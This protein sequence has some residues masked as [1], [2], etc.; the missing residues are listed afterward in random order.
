MSVIEDSIDVEVPIRTAYN[1]WTQ[2]EEFSKFMEGVERVEQRTDTL[3]HWVTKIGGIKREFDAE[4]TDQVPDQKVAWHTLEGSEQR[5]EVTF[6]PLDATHTRVLLHMEF[7]PEGI[8]EK[9]G[10]ALGIV[11]R[12]VHGDLERFK[13][14][15]EHRGA[16]TG[17]WRGEVRGGQEKPRGTP[18]EYDPYRGGA[19]TNPPTPGRNM[20]PSRPGRRSG[21][22]HV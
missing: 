14:F 20:P 5:G 10:D 6:V 4:I 16:E 2:F 18:G 22:A 15:I 9:A 13:E 3:T 1:Q 17:A 19:G 8:A 12:R 11:E 21:R 7:E